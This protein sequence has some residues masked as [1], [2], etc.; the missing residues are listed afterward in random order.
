MPLKQVLLDQRSQ[1]IEC[2]ASPFIRLADMIAKGDPVQFPA[3]YA[4]KYH[5]QLI[6]LYNVPYLE[7][8]QRNINKS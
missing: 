7:N 6:N 3:G 5:Q 8:K 4:S 2:R 1:N